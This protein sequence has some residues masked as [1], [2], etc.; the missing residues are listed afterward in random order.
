MLVTFHHVLPE[1]F[2]IR[3][4]INEVHFLLEIAFCGSVVQHIR[5]IITFREGSAADAVLGFANHLSWT[6]KPLG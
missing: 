2:L 1:L 4:V 5:N 3:Q 6:Q